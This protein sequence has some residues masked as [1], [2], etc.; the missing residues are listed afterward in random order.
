MKG[1]D[2]AQFAV[3]CRVHAFLLRNY[4]EMMCWSFLV[5]IVTE[6]NAKIKQPG[7]TRDR[8]WREFSE[9]VLTFFLLLFLLCKNE[10]KENTDFIGKK[11]A[12]F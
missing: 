2:E 6:S 1:C 10:E 3:Q 4:P 5:N 11:N 7:V 8:K 12:V 9:R